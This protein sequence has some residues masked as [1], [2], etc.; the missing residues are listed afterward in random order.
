MNLLGVFQSKGDKFY[1]WFEEAS[2]NNYKAAL[3][4]EKLCKNFKD[5]KKIADQ[6][7]T[8]EHN[9]DQISHHIYKELNSVFV[10][11]LDREDIIALT[12]ALDNVI[13]LI[14]A[15]ASSIV[16]YNVKKITPVA[17]ELAQ[18]ILASSKIVAEVLPKLRNRRGFP[19]VYKA[20]VEINRLENTAD[21]LLSSGLSK[22]FKKPKDP[23]DVIRW[24]DIYEMMEN[25]TDKTEDIAD[26]LQNLITKYA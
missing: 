1:R 9:G 25:T 17:L 13:D 16:T 21:D 26:V 14:H 11:P 6:I 24:R 22:L 18:T 5:P 20:I 7:H 23:I 3:L 4:L 2:E 12:Q 8:L 10:T 15:S 19:Q